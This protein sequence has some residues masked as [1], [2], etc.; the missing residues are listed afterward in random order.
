[1]CIFVG[2][3][4]GREVAKITLVWLKLQVLG[5]DVLPQLECEWDIFSVKLRLIKEMSD[6]MIIEDKY[7]PR[8]SIQ[9]TSLVFYPE[10]TT[11]EVA[12]ILFP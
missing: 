5:I 11:A 1:M 2:R 3:K 8:K 6:F 4:A 10:R 9:C 12:Y 7:R